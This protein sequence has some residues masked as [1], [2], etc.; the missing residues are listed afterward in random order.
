MKVKLADMKRLMETW[1]MGTQS[2]SSRDLEAV[3]E[4]KNTIPKP[5]KSWNRR[6]PS[7]DVGNTRKGYWRTTYSSILLRTL[8]IERVK[9]AGCLSVV[10]CYS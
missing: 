1:T 2:H 4:R 6:G 3:E 8:S 9:R 10:S 5:K 7:T